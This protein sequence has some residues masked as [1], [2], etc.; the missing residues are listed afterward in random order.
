MPKT[1]IASLLLLLLAL[2]GAACGGSRRDAQPLDEYLADLNGILDDLVQAR[3]EAQQ[4]HLDPFA[5]NAE[6]QIQVRAARRFL[7]DFRN[8]VDTFSADL[9]KLEPPDDLKEPHDELV[10]ASRQFLETVEVLIERLENVQDLDSL[11]RVLNRFFPAAGI[12][13]TACYVIEDTVI[14]GG[15]QVALNCAFEAP[16]E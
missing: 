12:V 4:K 3:L 16:E 13:T 7:S 6:L 5:Q 15:R 10:D 8:S 1:L 11:D 2:P 14:K 9:D